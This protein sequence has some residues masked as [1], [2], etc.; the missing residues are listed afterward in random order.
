MAEKNKPAAETTEKVM[1]KYDKKV[2]RRKEE[3]RKEQQRRKRNRIIGAVAAAALVIFI[4]YF[5]ISKYIATHSTYINVGGYDVT[6]V[7]FDYYYN[8][9][10][11]NYIAS[12]GSMISYMGLDTTKD[13]ADQMYSQYMTWDDF[14]QQNAVESLKRT[15]GLVKEGTE[16]GFVYDAAAET[17]MIMEA[18][19][20]AAAAAGMT[21][22]DYLKSSFGKYATAKNLRPIIEESYYATAY[23]NEIVRNKKDADEEITAYYE[24]HKDTYDSVDYMLAQVEADIPEG[25]STTDEEGNVTTADPTEEQIAEA[26]EAAKAEA[27]KMVKT[28]GADGELQENIKYTGAGSLYREWLFDAGR[29]AGDTTVVEDQYNH[30]YYVLRFEKRYLDPASTVNIRAISTD[31]DMG[32]TILAEWNNTGANEEAFIAL[33]EKYSNDTTTNRNGGLY[34]DLDATRLSDEI[35]SWMLEEDRASG[36]VTTINS[37]DGIHYVFYYIGQG[38]PVWRASVISQ[39]ASKYQD[40][41]AERVEVTDSKGRLSYLKALAA[42][43]AASQA[44]QDEADA[45]DEGGEDGESSDEENGSGNE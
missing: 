33:V 27:D 19:K 1:T 40:E 9:S 5:P 42:E 45:N 13:Y 34:E 14:F 29:K 22:K 23:Y 2:Q 26:M 28:V 35:G 37:T 7:E 21:S 4:A 39:L 15:K 17:D 18:L 30:R 24:E 8:I 31:E 44:A 12:W 36:D 11:S 32:E 6:E 16:K 38:E 25:E 41:M 10:A 43:E 20:D 3:E